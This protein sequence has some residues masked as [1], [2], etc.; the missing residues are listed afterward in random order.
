MTKRLQVRFDEAELLD[1]Q[2][3][4]MD[5]GMTTAE[6]VRASLRAALPAEAGSTTRFKLEAVRTAMS[7]SYPV[8]DIDQQLD[9]IES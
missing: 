3:F 2:R 7:Y 9:E 8:R 4:A 5:R 6:W 1:I